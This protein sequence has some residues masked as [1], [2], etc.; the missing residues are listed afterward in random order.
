MLGTAPKFDDATQYSFKWYQELAKEIHPTE[1]LLESNA[2]R[3]KF[4]VSM[5]NHGILIFYDHGDEDRLIGNDGNPILDLNNVELV[6]NKEVY[7]MCCLAAKKLGVEAYKKNCIWWGYTEVFGF[8]VEDEHLFMEAANIGAIYRFK[9][10]SSWKEC[11]ELAKEKFT[12]II[13]TAIDPWTKV[14]ARSNRDCLVCYNGEVPNT[15]CVLRKIVLKLFGKL[16]WKIK[17]NTVADTL[18]LIFYGIALHDYSHQV[19]QLKG[20]HNLIEGGYIGFIGGL[21]CWLYNKKAF[22]KSLCNKLRRK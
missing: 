9:Y 17:W 6:S 21:I 12:G 8:T 4:A 7:T 15:S 13:D 11:L 10:N 20:Y 19:Y 2:V 3:S 22:I 16:G 18:F 5:P 1:E 14:W